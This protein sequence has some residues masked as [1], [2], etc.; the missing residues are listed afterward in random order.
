MPPTIPDYLAIGHVCRDVA[1]TGYQPGGTAVYAALTAH[2]M[3]C[4]TAVLTSTRPDYDLSTVFP[5]EVALQRVPAAHD[6]IFANHDEGE[7]RHQVVRGV[8]DLLTAEHLPAPWAQSSIV[9]LGPIVH[10]I[11]PALINLFRNRLIGVTPQGWMRRWDAHGRVSAQPWVGAE[12]ICR[13]ATAVIL[14]EQDVLDEAMLESLTGWANL[15]VLTRGARGCTVYHHGRAHHL[16][17]VPVAAVDTTGAGDI[18][19]A[20]FLIHLWRNDG[21]PFEAARLANRHAAHAVTHAG[22]AEKVR[23]EGFGRER[24]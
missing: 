11:D 9:H 22:L 21:D 15:L 10:E 16:A 23:G 24:Y 19:A 7:V 2:H 8:A 1:P 13:K 3:G 20:A 6:T 18:F 4:R 12:A 14:S 17:G 5:P